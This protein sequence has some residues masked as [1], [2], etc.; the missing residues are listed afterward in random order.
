[1]RVLFE[2]LTG[3]LSSFSSLTDSIEKLKQFKLP[4]Y[5]LNINNHTCLIT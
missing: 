5:I 4:S 2:E 3:E 1:M